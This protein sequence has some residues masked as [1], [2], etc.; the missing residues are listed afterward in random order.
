[1]P[2][3]AFILYIFSFL[4]KQVISTHLYII[5]LLLYYALIFCQK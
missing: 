5:L 1:M 2:L 3:Y 4:L